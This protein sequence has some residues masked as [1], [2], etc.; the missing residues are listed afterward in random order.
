MRAGP[1]SSVHA[2]SGTHVPGEAPRSAELESWLIRHPEFQKVTSQGFQDGALEYIFHHVGATNKYYVVRNICSSIE[3]FK[4]QCKSCVSA[5]CIDHQVTPRCERLCCSE[6]PMF[7]NQATAYSRPRTQEFGFNSDAHEQGSGSNTY[8]LRHKYGWSGLLMDGGHS[9][10][11]INLQREMITSANVVELFDKHAVPH[12]PDY[13]SIDIDS[14][15]LWILR[16]VLASAYRPRVLTVEYNCVYGALPIAGTHPDANMPW[17][18]DNVHGCSLAAVDMV[19]QEFG[20]ALALVVPGLDAVL[21]RDDLLHNVAKPTLASFER[22]A[23]CNGHHPAT[24]E[25]AAILLDYSTW[26]LTRNE[27]AARAALSEQLARYSMDFTQPR[28]RRTPSAAP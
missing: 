14:T 28:G 20:W 1:C 25:R 27:A 4:D 6:S 7:I 15:D 18:G 13:V 24:A 11:S 12:A 8:Q 5:P 10:A 21:V 17:K 26:Q 16:A 2:S 3:P 19:A 9:N 23:G 22:V